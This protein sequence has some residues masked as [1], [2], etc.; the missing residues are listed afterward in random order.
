MENIKENE[1][2]EKQYDDSNNARSIQILPYQKEHFKRVL[3]ILRQEYGYMDVSPF[4]AGKT[5]IAFAVAAIFKLSIIVI[6]PKTAIENWRKWS[7][8][9]KVNLITSLSYQSLRGMK[10]SKLNHELLIKQEGPDIDR[11]Y[12]PTKKFRKY[13]QNGLL[14]VFDEVHNVKNDN[15]Q[16]QSA[17]ALVKEV[18]R[19]IRMGFKSRVA[20]LSATPSDKKET[21]TSILKIL[22]VIISDKLYNYNRSTKMYE[23]LGIQEAINK[24]LT[25]NQDETLHITCRPINKTTAKTIC[26]QLYKKVLK[27]HLTSSMPPPPISAEKDA[28]NFYIKMSP[29][30]VERLKKGIMLFSSAT[31]YRY[32]VQE[33]NMSKA[34]WANIIRS[35]TEIDSSKIDGICR[36]VKQNLKSNPQCK[37][38][39]YCNYIRDIKEAARQLHEYSPFVMFG[40]TKDKD[41]QK[42][43]SGFQQ[44]NDNHRILISNP[45][46][47]GV[48]IGLDDK[49]GN[50]PRTIYILPS[51]H[52]TDE[53]QATGRIHREGTKSKATIRFIYSKDF[54]FETGIL[55]SMALKSKVARDMVTKEQRTVMFPGEYDELI[56]EE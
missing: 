45:K 51:Y 43:I 50:R 48:G 27:Y 39:I 1:H 38:I 30:N 41:R 12:I 40:E 3:S 23:P 56:E 31:N 2:K 25:Y 19:G 34:N 53:Y 6:C 11:Q 22:G 9:Y 37:V 14:L 33:V 32:E 42:M 24:C 17:H 8:I 5:H 55:N 35:R 44:D 28:K 15:S 36:L 47:G 4:G 21:V 18:V 54:P 29:E 46:V 49:V 52:F 7:K 10:G 26:H 16:L 13:V 20:L